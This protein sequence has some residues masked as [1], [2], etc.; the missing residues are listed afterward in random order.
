MLP[1]SVLPCESLLQ[2]RAARSF[3]EKGPGTIV[4]VMTTYN[5]DQWIE[6]FEGQLTILRPHLT[7]R[8]LATMSNAAWHERGTKGE[9]PIKAAKAMSASLEQAG[10]PSK[11]PAP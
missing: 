9:D 2:I 4:R 10:N 1:K 3:V 5:R 11:K 7:E 8:V 6:S